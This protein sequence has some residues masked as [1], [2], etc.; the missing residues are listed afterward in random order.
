MPIRK[1][2]P[3]ESSQLFRDE[4]P[5][6]I[7]EIVLMPGAAQM[8]IVAADSAVGDLFKVI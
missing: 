2:L 7:A 5:I 8:D 4:G 1:N 3:V 6:L